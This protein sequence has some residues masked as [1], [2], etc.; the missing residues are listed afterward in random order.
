MQAT[1]TVVGQCTL[2]AGGLAV[3]SMHALCDGGTNCDGDVC[4][5]ITTV[6]TDGDG[7]TYQL[8]LTLSGSAQ[9]AYTIFGTDDS[10]LSI[11]PSYQQGAPFGS[12]TGGINPAFV[13][14]VA[15][16]A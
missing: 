3:D 6:S 12:N 10:P 11:P 14:I 1:A 9:N 5:T 16:C 13:D 7:T 15:T 2:A 8:G 4:G